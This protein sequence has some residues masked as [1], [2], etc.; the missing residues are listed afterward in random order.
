M[1][2][3]ELVKGNVVNELIGGNGAM[4]NTTGDSAQLFLV[5]DIFTLNK[6]KL[7][8][9]IAFWH[10]K[11][12]NFLLF[13]VKVGTTDWAVAPCTPYKCK[14]YKTV[15]YSDGKGMPLSIAKVDNKTGKIIDLSL[16]SLDTDFSNSMEAICDEILKTEFNDFQNQK[17]LQI[18]YKLYS[19]DKKIVGKM[20]GHKYIIE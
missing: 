19:A 2:A 9:S 4:F 16:V 20:K 5:S 12:E 6:F 15:E 3:T 13:G 17:D 10:T 11:Y 1:D 14:D 18:L 7:N 8:G